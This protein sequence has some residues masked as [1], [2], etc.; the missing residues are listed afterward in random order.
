[1]ATEDNEGFINCDGNG[2][3]IVLHNNN[4]ESNVTTYSEPVSEI[5][6]HF[7]N[8]YNISLLDICFNNSTVNTFVNDS[9]IDCISKMVDN[10]GKNQY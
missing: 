9:T 1:M 10:S 7:P 8:Q 5:V 2:S 3:E 4:S 6:A